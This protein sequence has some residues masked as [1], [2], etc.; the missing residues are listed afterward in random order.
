MLYFMISTFL[1]KMATIYFKEHKN[2]AREKVFFEF[3]KKELPDAEHVNLNYPLGDDLFVNFIDI[4]KII[5][6]LEKDKKLRESRRKQTIEALTV[7]PDKVRVAKSINDVSVDFAIVSENDIHFIE[8]HEDQHRRLTVERKTPIICTDNRRFEIP[9]F[10]Q[11][12]LKDIWRMENLPNYKIAWWDWFEENK[13]KIT[14]ADILASNKRE[15]SIPGTFTITEL[16][17][18]DYK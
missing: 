13:D 12:L 5:A 14:I 7:L 18:L 16:L 2:R 15:F 9:R 1:R 8:F 11:R 4:P 17:K 6:L 10:V 3:L